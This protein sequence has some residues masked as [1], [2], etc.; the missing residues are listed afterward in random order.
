MHA[1]TEAAEPEPTAAGNHIRLSRMSDEL[2]ARQAARGGERAFTAIYE[3]YHQ[4]LYRYC[5]S[6]VRE[7]ADAQ[8]ALQSTFTK[9]LQALRG[10]RRNA[11]LRPW[12]YRIAHNE[13]ISVIRRRQRDHPPG[14]ESLGSDVYET[15]LPVA[16]PEESLAL[17]ERWRTLV[18][19]LAELPE[20]QRG[21]LLL[22]ELS[23]LPHEEIALALG[24]TA[25]AAKQSI[26][27]ARQALAEFAEG[28]EMECDEVRRRISDGDGR[29]LRGRRVRGHLRGCPGCTAFATEIRDRQTELRAATPILAPVAAGALLSRTLGAAGSHAAAGS[30][31]ASSGAVGS[32]L[33][34][35]VL[36]GTLAWKAAAGVAVIATTAAVGVTAIDHSSGPAGHRHTA[37]RAA[38]GA[39]GQAASR[40]THRSA[41]A[42]PPDALNPAARPARGTRVGTAGRRSAASAATQRAAHRLSVTKAEPGGFTVAPGRS[43]SSNASSSGVS[44]RTSGTH[45]KSHSSTTSH[46]RRPRPTHSSQGSSATT[47]PSSTTLTSPTLPT[48]PGPNARSQAQI[49]R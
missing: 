5:R 7:D 16:S 1:V 37:H 42:A 23:G 27:E 33:A 49:L 9:A 2:L 6:I 25:S 3:R 20:R 36:G 22:R 19:D 29:V 39:A 44:H 38:G 15:G 4:P 12:L 48:L 8:D 18:A 17:K 31:V 34:S 41:V 11:P 45:A 10:N 32:G 30:A 46:G 43:S 26:F 35:K 40:A 47:A 28:R 13:A 21:A 14:S 24:T